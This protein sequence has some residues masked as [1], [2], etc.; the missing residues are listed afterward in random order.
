VLRHSIEIAEIELKQLSQSD[1][2]FG[3]HLLSAYIAAEKKERDQ[4]LKELQMAIDA[5]VAG[6]DSW[7]SAAEVHAI[8]DD[9]PGV[10][11]ALEKAAQRKEPTAAYVL[12]HPLYRYLESDARFQKL[13]ETLVAQQTEIRTALAQ[14]N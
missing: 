4:A 3:Y 1:P 13:K 6:D 8:L 2:L 9:T 10:L 12:A 5:G 14:V 7:T 11:D